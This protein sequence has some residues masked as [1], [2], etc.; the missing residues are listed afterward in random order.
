[1]KPLFGID[2]TENKKNDQV[3]G[4]ELVKATA[5]EENLQRLEEHELFVKILERNAKLP[6]AL[7]VVKG[8]VSL[9]AMIVVIGVLRALSGSDGISLS[10][11]FENAPALFYIGGACLVVWAVL[12]LIEKIKYNSAFKG[13]A[14]E[15]LNE[16]T[17]IQSDIH[18]ELGVPEGTKTTEILNF[19]YKMKNDV[20]MA[21]AVGTNG[22]AYN[23]LR[24]KI[25]SDGDNL[26]LVDARRRYEI[27]LNSLRAI[28]TVNKRIEVPSWKKEESFVSPEYKPYSI[29]RNKYG[30]CSFKP[31]HIL[32]FDHNG[33]IWGLYFPCYELPTFES[34]TLIKAEKK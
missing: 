34:L 19:R 16:I 6:P 25:Y 26:C 12:A 31:Y 20:P 23:N 28:R 9:I 21:K 22:V 29:A 4:M 24:I 33:E 18:S 8:I 14:E 27:P 3:N 7:R 10:R 5:S 11:A 15:K 17:A 13:N 32:E 2:I 30:V 1:M